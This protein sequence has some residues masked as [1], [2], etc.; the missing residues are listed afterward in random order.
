TDGGTAAP[1]ART[2]HPLLP[3]GRSGPGYGVVSR[4]PTA[5]PPP[6]LRPA[7]AA[8][9]KPR[10]TPG[11]VTKS[12]NI[13]QDLLNS[14]R[15]I[16]V[17]DVLKSQRTPPPGGTVE[18]P[19]PAGA[20][21]EDEEGKGKVRPG[22]VTGRDQRRAQR[23]QRAK[24][25][26]GP[27]GAVQLEGGRVTVME[28]DRPS[29]YRLKHRAKQRQKPTEERKSEVV[30][31]TPITVRSL[32]EAIGVGANRV[33]TKLLELNML[34]TINSLV[35]AD[36][37]ELVAAD[38]GVQVKIRKQQDAEQVLEESLKEPDDPA[39]LKP[40]APV[41]TVMGHVDHGKTSLLDKIRKSNVVDTEAGGITQ[42]IRAWRVEYDGGDGP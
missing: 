15:P 6:S 10:P 9:P 39:A 18:A 23:D 7:D 21:E 31:T 24:E 29:R 36:M 40:R 38:A 8:A 32:S 16:T 22:K 2:R 4:T 28:D 14:G 33:I 5:K 26:K 12:A 1:P 25:R 42:V 20:E 27:V 3:R 11:G 37:A 41:V 35:D 17:S 34:A 19:P 30:L 13:T